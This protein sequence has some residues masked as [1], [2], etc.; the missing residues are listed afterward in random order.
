MT[1]T[2]SAAAGSSTAAFLSSLQTVPVVHPAHLET[3]D[4]SLAT[5]ILPAP[6]PLPLPAPSAKRELKRPAPPP[7][8]YLPASDPGSTFS[9]AYATVTYA[10]PEDSST[11]RPKR[12]RLLT[13]PAPER[14][15]DRPQR[16]TRPPQRIAQD[17]GKRSSPR[18]QPDP[19]ERGTSPASPSADD[20]RERSMSI[21]F[22]AAPD[23]VGNAADSDPNHMSN[24][25]NGVA[26]TAQEPS[27]DPPVDE[28]LLH[29]NDHCSACRSQGALLYCDGCPRAFHLWCL[30]PPI[31]PDDPP[32]EAKWLCP[33]CEPPTFKRRRKV[34]NHPAFSPLFQTLR[35]RVPAEF[36]LPA[37]I[38][39]HFR[40]VATGPR[41]GYLG[42][43]KVPRPHRHGLIEDRDPYKL[44]EKDS[45]AVLCFRCNK[46]A[47]SGSS[48]GAKGTV[49]K[50]ARLSVDGADSRRWRS[51][52]SCDYCDLHWHLDCLD[53]PLTVMPPRAHKWMCPNHV[54]KVLPT[55]RIPKHMH[56][57]LD[58]DRPGLMNNGNIDIVPSEDPPILGPPVDEVFIGGQK[59]R[60]PER[61]VILDFWDR[62]EQLRS[63]RL[64]PNAWRSCGTMLLRLSHRYDLGIP[65]PHRKHPL[66][67]LP[68]RTDRQRCI[69]RH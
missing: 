53:P 25:T 15:N 3:N 18:A 41:G 46:S 55:R 26:Q 40:D 56:K 65:K 48:Q 27:K 64:N 20:E 11:R 35:Q 10:G 16:S 4:I 23:D 52:V 38:R 47:F 7:P 13:R 30:D 9:S 43:G 1:A 17:G 63:S 69:L 60:V 62:C 58:V 19:A 45:A 57:T 61:V 5:E 59:Y 49:S 68:K 34:D 66:N 29:N 21:P 31:E 28:L 54:D 50:R 51:I 24:L 8:S 67:T 32:R 2:A 39:G 6:P 14:A 33:S 44:R 22:V 42:G 37:D 12:A 36:Q